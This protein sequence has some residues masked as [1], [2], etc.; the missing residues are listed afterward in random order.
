MAITKPK[1]KRLKIF[2][3]LFFIIAPV[4]YI[5]YRYNYGAGFTF[6]IGKK[7]SKSD[8]T[9]HQQ[10]FYDA[11]KKVYRR[12]ETEYSL[13]FIS[14]PELIQKMKNLSA[15]ERIYRLETGNN[16]DSGQMLSTYTAGMEVVKGHNSFPY[17]WSSLQKFAHEYGVPAHKFSHSAHVEGGTGIVKKYIKFP[18]LETAISFLHWTIGKRGNDPAKWHALDVKSPLYRK[19]LRHLNKIK[20]PIFSLLYSESPNSHRYP[21]T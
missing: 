13:G 18:D 6:T 9:L 12:I 7:A 4:L 2:S 20:N 16:F 19:Y 10:R 14:K 8:F 1:K 15:V 17:G 3:I 5:L 21:L 11:L